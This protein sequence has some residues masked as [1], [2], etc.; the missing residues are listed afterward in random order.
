MAALWQRICVITGGIISVGFG[1]WHLFVPYLYKWKSYMGDAPEELLRAVMATNFFMGLSLAIL[2]AI[3]I[4]LSIRFYQHLSFVR[5]WMLVMSGLW[6]VRVIYQ[7][8][9]P[10][11]RMI[12][13]L[14]WIMLCAF[15]LTSLLFLIPAISSLIHVSNKPD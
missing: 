2:G 15:I 6:L 14:S 9:S 10:Q 12:P 5:I 3:T 8:V 4:L 1:L 7:V 11:G 13:G